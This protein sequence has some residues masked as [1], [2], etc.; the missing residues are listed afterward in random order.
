MKILLLGKDGQ[1]GQ[2]LQRT[3]LP[4]GKV[5]ALGR[6][7]ANLEDPASIERALSSHAPGIIV[8][9]AAYT[10]VDKA[11]SD[12]TTARKINADAVAVLAQYANRTNA[13]LVHYSTDYV[14][15]GEKNSSYVETDSTG[16]QS[17]YGRTKL[18]GEQA[19]VQSNCHALVFR[20]SWV[21]S[22]HGGNFIK[23]IMRLAK[24]RDSLSI[25][26]DQIGAP[27]SAELLADVTALA[28][29]A[30]KQQ[31]PI[32]AGIYHLA[33]S[34]ETSWHGL[35][36]HVVKRLEEKGVALALSAS[37]IRAIGTDEYP[38]PAIRPKNSRL[39][40]SKLSN[41]LGLEIPHW[42]IYADRTID[43]LTKTDKK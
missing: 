12:E 17:A 2:E 15:D 11:E 3:L 27:T 13:L 29:A 21:F 40:T 35:A 18:E 7:D 42:T 10:A 28:I 6:Q 14:Y 1:V 16:P 9:A 19:I 37:E 25:V 34:G 20:T 5:I 41:A 32:K 36:T 26:A 43:Q 39:D 23:T 4:L 30:Y 22:A 38:L 8:N 31:K 24:E 33:A